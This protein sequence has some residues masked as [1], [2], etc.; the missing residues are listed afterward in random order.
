MFF[1]VIMNLASLGKEKLFGIFDTYSETNIRIYTQF[2]LA[3]R[4]FV[5]G[6]NELAVIL[7][8]TP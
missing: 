6:I 4:M 3:L 7:K 1:T 2:E 5:S 8:K